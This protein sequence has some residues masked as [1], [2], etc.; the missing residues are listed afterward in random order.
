[1]DNKKEIENTEKRNSIRV[2]KWTEIEISSIKPISNN[3]IRSNTVDCEV[4]LSSIYF[5]WRLK[6][7]LRSTG[8]NSLMIGCKGS[9]EVSIPS[10]IIRIIVIVK[11]WRYEEEGC[12]WRRERVV[13]RI[14]EES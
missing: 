1:M 8:K 14:E 7:R 2:N 11:K 9:E 4:G 6:E 12:C 5:Y 10:W 13:E 3:R